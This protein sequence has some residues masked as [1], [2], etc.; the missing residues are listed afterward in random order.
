VTFVEEKKAT[1]LFSKLS[2]NRFPTDEELIQ[3]IKQVRV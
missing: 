3:A 2:L 1:L